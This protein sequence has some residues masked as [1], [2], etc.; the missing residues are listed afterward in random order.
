MLEFQRYQIAFTAHI[1]NPSA[2]KKPTRVPDGRMAIYREIVFNNIFGSVSACFPVC[3]SVLGARA[4]RKIVRAFFANHQASSPIFREIP[5]QFLQFLKTVENLPVYLQQLAHYEWVELAVS[6]QQTEAKKL[7]KKADLLNEKP[8]LAPAHILLAYDYAVHKI[9]KRN[10]P[11]TTES[12]YL[13]VFRNTE[14]KVKFIELNPMTFQLL[15]L[16]EKNKLTGIQAL[17][18]LA[19]EIAS[20]DVDVIIQFGVEILTDLEKQQAIVGSNKN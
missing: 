15:S 10:T 17:T 5:Q 4:W 19:V 11:K 9:S 12:T 14:N 2:N 7:S 13:L 3:K 20:T 1:R 6:A 16:I 8:V 18:R